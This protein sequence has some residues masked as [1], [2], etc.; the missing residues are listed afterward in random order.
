VR[1]PLPSGEAATGWP[2]PRRLHDRLNLELLRDSDD[3]ADNLLVVLI[4]EQIPNELDV[5]L[6]VIDRE[7]PEA[8]EGSVANAEV[9]EGKR[10]S[11][12]A[13]PLCESPRRGEVLSRCGF[14]DLKDEVL[15]WRSA[16]ED[17]TPSADEV[18]VRLPRTAHTSHP[19]R[20]HDFTRLPAR[21]R[22]GPT[23]PGRS[24]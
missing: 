2:H 23:H 20:I 19:W 1:S 11:E 12:L 24:R 6:Q 10:A 17:R 14:G 16:A 7:M 15:W 13:Q 22:V 9:V 8:C 18:Q 5:D 21:G 4:I 3:R